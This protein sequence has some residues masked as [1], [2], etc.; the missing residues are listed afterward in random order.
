MTDE[1]VASYQLRCFPKPAS[2]A[3]GQGWLPELLRQYPV[4][5]WRLSHRQQ[6]ALARLIPMLLCGEQSA[7]FVFNGHAAQIRQGE[8]IEVQRALRRIEAEEAVHE[9][10]LQ[11]LASILPPP[12]DLH[13]L[14]RRAQRFYTGLGQGV[15]LA[16][17]FARIEALDSG[18]CRIMQ[19]LVLGDWGS[20]PALPL[21]FDAIKRDEARHVGIS[22]SYALN[23]GID[24]RTREHQRRHIADQLVAYLGTEAAAFEPL[25]VDADRLFAGLAGRAA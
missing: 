9:R 23:L 5:S 11:T 24:P 25:G 13:R 12:D 1:R 7:Q 14:K 17:H 16:E 10:A 20:A 4:S 3:E 15:T 21:M 6:E 18:V 2:A 8:S 19:A 22:R